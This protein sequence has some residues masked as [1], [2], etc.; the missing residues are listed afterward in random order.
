MIGQIEDFTTDRRINTEQVNDYPPGT[1]PRAVGGTTY[2]GG[3]VTRNQRGA[4]NPYTSS[5]Y[6]R[7]GSGGRYRNRQSLRYL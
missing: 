7:R 5:G 6:S 1:Y 3:A 4:N 2:Y